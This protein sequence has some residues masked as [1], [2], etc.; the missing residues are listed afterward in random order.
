M[1]PNPENQY[2]WSF[3]AP[4]RPAPARTEAVAPRPPARL[5]LVLGH[6]QWLQW[7]ADEWWPLSGAPV[8]LGVDSARGAAAQ[9]R[10]A[11][12]V[13]A[14]I[15]PAR[16]PPI[17]VSSFRDAWVRAPLAVVAASDRELEWPGPVPLH[18]VTSFMVASEADRSRLMA[19]SKAF[20][21][22]A[23]PAQ[24]IEVG[25][26]DLQPPAPDAPPRSGDL[27]LPL[28]W[29]ARRGA[30][31][32]AVWSVPAVAPWLKA[33]CDSLALRPAGGSP[34]LRLGRW[35][36]E[37]PWTRR[38]L[39]GAGNDAQLQL[40]RAAVDVLGAVR[41][42]EAWRPRE[43]AEAIRDRACTE[44][45][46]SRQ[47]LDPFLS[48]TGALLGDER[49]V[50]TSLSP[51]D[52]VGSAIQLV[53]LRPA[54]DRFLGWA[55]DVAELPPGVWWM[56]VMLSGLAFGYRDL[57]LR[58]RGTPEARRR[59]ALRLW[60]LDA[61]ESEAWGRWPGATDSTPTW[62][63][64]DGGRVALLWDG[65]RW[66]E[67]NGA[68]RGHWYEADLGRKELRKAAMALA[69]KHKPSCVRKRLELANLKV[70]YAG[71]GRIRAEE[72][73][74][75][76][77]GTVQL[78]LPPDV[79]IVEDLD[80][81]AFRLWL[82]R[83]GIAERLVDPPSRGREKRVV[84]E[85]AD[86]QPAA[87]PGL[88]IVPDFITEAEERALLEAVD[89][90][91]WIES[92]A[93][94]VQHY[95]WRY[96]YK[97]RRV[98]PGARLGSLPVWAARLGERLLARGL[99]PELPDQLIVNE[100]VGAQGITKH[101]DCRPCF[102]GPIVTLSLGESWD[103][104]LWSPEGDAKVSRLLPRRS[105]TVLSGEVRERWKHEIP[106]RANEASGPRGRRVS[107]TF[108]KVVVPAAGEG[109]G[110]SKKRR[111]PAAGK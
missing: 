109:S 3:L 68:A 32:L 5:G 57:E 35:V 70:P 12:T 56:G 105:A 9:E 6:E 67:R 27:P 2:A 86:S 4:E 42:R 84:Y 1:M 62:R 39:G 36:A 17:E 82:A 110:K 111:S 15:D 65:E 106:R 76:V 88:S 98:D 77:E 75:A 71:P 47:D 66:A 90:E 58:F 108:R 69:R 44:H 97:A 50:E 23:A 63:W 34:D 102:Q 107:L 99:V 38:R 80:E 37:L 48:L 59:L 8:R 21:N 24:P 40:W 49:S 93:R 95:G 104:F 29:N 55:H 43:I 19:M 94:R 46:A 25:A 61:L 52:P 92:M 79:E 73:A 20:S 10:G 72:G 31:A 78:D 13:V 60:Q 18:A 53:L 101:V 74:L 83:D 89:Q 51:N 41:M 11:V 96:D 22:V 87:I 7:L 14:W 103:M 26:L 16:L 30:L 64:E 28:D 100:Y 54:P 85:V 91:P 33:L 45:G 81:E